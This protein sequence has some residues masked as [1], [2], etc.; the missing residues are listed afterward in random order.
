MFHF[1]TF[2]KCH[3][4]PTVFYRIFNVFREYTIGTLVWNGL[5]KTDKNNI[6]EFL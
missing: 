6:I 2:W 5:K 4:K 1:Y 3:T